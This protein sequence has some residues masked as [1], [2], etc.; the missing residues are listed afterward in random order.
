MSPAVGGTRP[1]GPGAILTANSGDDQ[2]IP[3]DQLIGQSNQ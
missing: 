1:T 3:L 2:M